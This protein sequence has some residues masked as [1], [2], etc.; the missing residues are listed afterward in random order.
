MSRSQMGCVWFASVFPSFP[1]V[2]SLPPLPPCTHHQYRR[3]AERKEEEVGEEDEEEEEKEEEK[4]K[5]EFW[6][7]V[8]LKNAESNRARRR[9]MQGCM[10]ACTHGTKR[11]ITNEDFR[12]GAV[13]PNSRHLLVNLGF[14]DFHVFF[15]PIWQLRGS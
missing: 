5:E 8:P 1:M 7:G 9:R 3:V 14:H 2:S 15:L 4:K 13:P 10:H 11:T 6:D 12:F